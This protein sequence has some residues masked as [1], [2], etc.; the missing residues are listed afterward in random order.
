[1]GGT[2]PAYRVGSIISADLTVENAAAVRDF[3]EGVIGWVID[4]FD[5]GGYNDYMVKTADGQQLV[6]GLCHARGE[7]AGLPPVWLVYINVA[8]LG[9]SIQRCVELGGKVLVQNDQYAVVQDP[10]GAV[11]AIAHEPEEAVG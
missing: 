1:M 8:D 3:Y 5:M 4:D 11:L 6:G 9:L 10:A 7:N 2:E